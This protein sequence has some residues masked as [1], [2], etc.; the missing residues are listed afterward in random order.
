MKKLFRSY[1]II[2]G[3]LLVLFNIIAFAVPGWNGQE[4]YT[5]SFFVGYGFITLALVG[6]LAC[7]WFALG[8]SDSSRKFFYNLSLLTVSRTG[9]LTTF[10]CG[11][12]CMLIAPLPWWVGVILCAAVL[13]FTAIAVVKASAAADLV[14][15]V[16]EKLGGNTLFIKSLAADAQSLVAR[17]GSEEL[18]AACKKVY[19]AAR[20][21]DPVSHDA[22]ASVESE[23]TLRFAALSDA[24][25]ENNAEAATAA[26]KELLLLLNAR[27]NKCRILK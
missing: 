14:G 18:R 3:I 21:S 17:A 19:E 22:L 5:A 11:G 26:A 16:D 8:K 12:A 25:K 7:A 6:Q 24:V 13:A 2:W 15:A 4:K 9:L 20:Y 27:N 10:A 1:L 23:I